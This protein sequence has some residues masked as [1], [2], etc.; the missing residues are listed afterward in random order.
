MCT[1][2]MPLLVGALQKFARSFDS[3]RST[4]DSWE[5]G[6]GRCYTSTK[7]EFHSAPDLHPSPKVHP[8]RTSLCAAVPRCRGSRSCRNSLEVCESCLA[9]SGY[10]SSVAAKD[11]VGRALT[12]GPIDTR[13]SRVFITFRPSFTPLHPS[14]ICLDERP[15]LCAA[16]RGVG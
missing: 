16:V 5:T 12:T 4:P 7:A 3:T 9:F 15:H 6:I 11:V 2:N 10:F 8:A 1:I 13:Q 14:L